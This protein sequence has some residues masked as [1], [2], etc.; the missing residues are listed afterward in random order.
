MKTKLAIALLILGT[1]LSGI[2]SAIG[3]TTPPSLAGSWQLTFTP[4]APNPTVSGPAFSGLATFTTD[5]STIETDS[6]E[7]SLIMPVAT[8]AMRATPGHGIWQPAPAT[9]HLFIQFISIVAN[10]NGSLYARKTVT[11]TGA[12]DSSGNNFT[13]GYNYTV[14]DPRG[15]SLGM[16][17]GTI[18]GQR[19]PHPVL[20]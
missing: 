16:G 5:G 17:S 7:L 12:L 11:I 14:I 2:E 10:G 6:S 4:T 15:T 19:I 18:T 13:G 3:Q 9:G 1:A 20:P 8:A